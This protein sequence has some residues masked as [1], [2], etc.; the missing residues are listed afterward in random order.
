MFT[1]S[2]IEKNTC[3]DAYIYVY[4]YTHVHVFTHLSDYFF[5]VNF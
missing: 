3:I 2:H 1:Y 4:I 5:G